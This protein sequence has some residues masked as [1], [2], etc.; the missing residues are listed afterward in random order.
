LEKYPET[1]PALDDTDAQR[2]MKRHQEIIVAVRGQRA[3]R[4]IDK[5]VRLTGTLRSDTPVDIQLIVLSTN[6]DF[7]QISSSEP[8]WDVFINFPQTTGPTIEQRER[9]SKE[10]EQLEKVVANS[11]RQLENG[12]FVQKAPAHVIDGMRAKLAEYEAQLAKNKAALG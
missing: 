2:L 3:D 1:D 10:N 7:T 4:K 9:L 12:S 6:T 11:K 8:G 5:K